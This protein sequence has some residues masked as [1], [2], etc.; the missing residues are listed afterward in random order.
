MARRNL[1]ERL[2]Q[3]VRT[4]HYVDP[5]MQSDLQR[6]GLLNAAEIIRQKQR[7]SE[8]Y[9]KWQIRQAEIKERDKKF[10]RFWLGFGAL[11]GLVLLVVVF[12][13]G[14]WLWTIAG[15]GVLAVPVVLLFAGALAAG[16]HRCITIVQHMH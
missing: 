3:P 16:G 13:G 8:L 5:A 4:I 15:L 10:R 7:N 14:W 9:L 2:V 12:I 1:P 11:V 6:Y